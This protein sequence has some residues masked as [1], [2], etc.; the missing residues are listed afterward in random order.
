MFYEVKVKV[1]RTMENGTEKEVN[2]HYILDGCTLFAEAE[3]KMSE[4]VAADNVEYDVFSI[5]RSKVI[6]IINEKKEDEP[7]YKATV[8]ETF[9]DESGKEKEQ[10]YY[11]LVCAK[12]VR[13]ANVIM[14]QHLSQGLNDMT[15]DGIVKTKILDLLK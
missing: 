9:V 2:E 7:F 8:T 12:D 13:E 6:E 5:V 1:T 11:M 4:F 14:E 15:L 3:E 10:K